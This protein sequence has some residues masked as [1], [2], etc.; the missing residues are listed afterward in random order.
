MV[1]CT[2]AIPGRWE[3]LL[4]DV[5]PQ[6]RADG[7]LCSFAR[8]GF[9]DSDADLYSQGDDQNGKGQAGRRECGRQGKPEQ[10]DEAL[11]Y[12]FKPSPLIVA[13]LTLCIDIATAT[14]VAQLS[15]QQLLT[16]LPGRQSGHRVPR[17]GFAAVC[18]PMRNGR[19]RSGTD[20]RHFILLCC[21][22]LARPRRMGSTSIL[23]RHCDDPGTRRSPCEEALDHR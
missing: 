9:G 16:L 12:L 1:D 7:G 11:F 6:G 8:K 15:I 17:D 22:H 2:V 5:F 10:E 19:G 20:E 14:G 4:A 13:G 3:L 18:C 23:G 21:L